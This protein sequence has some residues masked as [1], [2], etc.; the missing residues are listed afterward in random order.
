M[1]YG[2]YYVAYGMTYRIMCYNRSV[3][4]VVRIFLTLL[5][6]LNHWITSSL[7]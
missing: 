2:L 1:T 7:F 3:P 5:D 4:K 6:V